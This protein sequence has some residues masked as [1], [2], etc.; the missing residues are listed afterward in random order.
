MSKASGSIDRCI[1]LLPVAGSNPCFT[2]SLAICVGGSGDFIAG[3]AGGGSGC[4]R[5]VG[6]VVKASASRAARLDLKPRGGFF[7]VVI[8]V[9]LKQQ[10]QQQ[11][12]WH[13]SAYPYRRL[14]L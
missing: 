7:L 8:P 1:A 10:Q 2:D 5:P 12:S 14:A 4:V 3:V 11:Q 13:S 9:T 6:L